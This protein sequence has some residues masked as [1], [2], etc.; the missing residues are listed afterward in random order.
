MMDDKRVEKED[1]S[2]AQGGW[3]CVWVLFLAGI[4]GWFL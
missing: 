4:F 3:I 2:L 1:E